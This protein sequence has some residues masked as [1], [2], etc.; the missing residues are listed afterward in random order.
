MAFQTQQ[1]ERAVN[2]PENRPQSPEWD[3]FICYASEDKD[4]FVRPLA[5]A[6][7]AMG[8]KVWFDEH[9]LIV[10]DSISRSIDT[11]LAR[12]SFGIVVISQ[13]FFGKAWP[14]RE[15]SG[16]VSREIESGKVILPIWHG[17]TRKQVLDYSPPLADIFALN[18]ADMKAEDIAIQLLRK[19]RPDLYQQHPRSDLERIASGEALN[20][21][22]E[23]IDNLKEELSEFQCPYCGAPV[24]KPLRADSVARRDSWTECKKQKNCNRLGCNRPPT[25]NSG[26][27]GASENQKP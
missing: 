7:K 8:L 17:V 13:S 23:E 27:R 2:L 18:T 3:V 19:I 22:R 20:D 11:G 6:L 16:L 1:N 12:S 25:E 10:G 21:L 14:E 24:S 15:L 26:W 5:T 9:S 4:S